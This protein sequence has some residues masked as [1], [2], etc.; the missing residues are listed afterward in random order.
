[1]SQKYRD[2]K[3]P[4]QVCRHQIHQSISHYAKEVKKQRRSTKALVLSVAW[5]PE[6]AHSDE[7]KSRFYCSTL[8][9]KSLLPMISTEEIYD[10]LEEMEEVDLPKNVAEGY[11]GLT[12]LT[13]Y[14]NSQYKASN[15]ENIMWSLRVTTLGAGSG[16]WELDSAIWSYTKM[17]ILLWGR[18]GRM[19]LKQNVLSLTK[20]ISS[21]HARSLPTAPKTKSSRHQE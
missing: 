15:L 7:N 5:Y 20:A 19:L 4:L 11:I 17:A 14:Q 9:M 3:Y 21:W 10:D 1:M 13:V 2:F 18:F 16:R 8:T 12:R 6:N